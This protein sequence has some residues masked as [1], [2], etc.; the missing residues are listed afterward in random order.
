VKKFGSIKSFAKS[1]GI[2]LTLVAF[3]SCSGRESSLLRLVPIE[4]CA[5]MLVDW[6]FVR[7]EQGLK[8]LINGNEF[9]ALVMRLGV[10]S[11]SVKSLVVFSAMNSETNAGL[12]LRGSFDRRR[13]GAGLKELGWLEDSVEGHRVYVKANDYVALPETNTVFAGTREAASSVF[14]A[15]ES[16][17]ESIVSS[18]S[19]RKLNETTSANTNPIRAFLVIPQGTLDMADASLTATSLGLSLF[20]LGGIGELLKAVNVASGFAFTLS[21]GTNQV[22]PVELCVLMRDEKAAVFISGS[23]NAMKTASAMASGNNQESLRA[24]QNMTITRRKEVLAIKVAMPETALF[25]LTH[26]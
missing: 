14:R 18:P 7:N 10:E 4:S 6:P 8:R 25:P 19:Y 13:V 26:P 21:R 12:L 3:F 1:L 20:N 24:L 11:Q 16:S 23:L 2:A 15:L 17:R 5:V 9:E 22:Y